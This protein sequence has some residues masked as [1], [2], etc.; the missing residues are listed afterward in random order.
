MSPTDGVEG[1]PLDGSLAP[2][3][4]TFAEHAEKLFALADDNNDG[5]LSL[6]EFGTL[7]EKGWG[8]AMSASSN[9]RSLPASLVSPPPR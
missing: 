1:T 2:V 4:Q 7:V 9:Q 3:Q 6:E 5:H 8:I